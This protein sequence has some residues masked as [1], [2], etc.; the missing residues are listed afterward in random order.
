MQDQGRLELPTS[1]VYGMGNVQNTIR[2][3]LPPPKPSF[4]LCVTFHGSD[5][6]PE[7]ISLKREEAYFGS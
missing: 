7:K 5:E 1:D 6:M 4:L 2:I 3:F